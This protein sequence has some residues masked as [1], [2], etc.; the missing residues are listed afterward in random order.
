LLRRGTRA[1]EENGREHCGGGGW[2]KGRAALLLLLR[3][4][5]PVLVT[6]AARREEVTLSMRRRE[7]SVERMDSWRMVRTHHK[8][9]EMII[10]EFAR[11]GLTLR[12]RVKVEKVRGD[13]IRSAEAFFELQWNYILNQQQQQWCSKTW[14]SSFT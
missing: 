6:V 12:A 7:H 9:L 3:R 2:W 4:D 13:V 8:L 14:K 1:E 5:D 10:T 11:N